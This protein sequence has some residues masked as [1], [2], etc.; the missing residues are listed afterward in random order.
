MAYNFSKPIPSLLDS[1]SGGGSSFKYKP[2]LTTDNYPQ[3]DYLSKGIIPSSSTAMQAGPLKPASNAAQNGQSGS[4]A[5]QDAYSAVK[6]LQ[7]GSIPSWMGKKK[8]EMGEEERGLI[9]DYDIGGKAISARP[10]LPPVP[11][12]QYSGGY[13]G[14][15]GGGRGGGFGGFG[16]ETFAGMGIPDLLG[17]KTIKAYTDVIS[18][19][20]QSATD[21]IQKME[22]Q[23]ALN[24]NTTAQEKRKEQLQREL[25]ESTPGYTARGVWNPATMGATG[26]NATIGG[27]RGG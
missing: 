27:S 9:F 11:Q 14:G 15:G 16:F 7:A 24:K 4:N 10:V 21:E 5:Y 3:Q 20:I 8:E 25:M 6:D 26:I 18:R 1:Y 12:M 19:P 13:G 2:A 22:A 17:P 23:I